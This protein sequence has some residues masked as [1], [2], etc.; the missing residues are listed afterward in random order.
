MGHSNLHYPYQIDGTIIDSVEEEKDLGVIIDSKPSFHR[1]IMEI[2]KKLI[3]PWVALDAPLNSRRGILWSRF[4]MP[5]SVQ[6]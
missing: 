4:I 5:M 2:I 6:G 1:H 3:T